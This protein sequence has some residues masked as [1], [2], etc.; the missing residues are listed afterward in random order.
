MAVPE[1]GSKKYDTERAR[2]R[3]EA[4]RSGISDKDANEAANEALQ[5]D[6]EL[7]SRGPRTERGRGPK[8]E[9]PENA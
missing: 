7:R 6:P 1:P 9:R 5:D 2:L 3:K 4:E 8:G